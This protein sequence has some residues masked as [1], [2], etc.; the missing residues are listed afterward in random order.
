MPALGSKLFGPLGFLRITCHLVA[1]Y[2]CRVYKPP[3]AILAALQLALAAQLAYIVGGTAKHPGG[4]SCREH[5]V[6]VFGKYFFVL[7]HALKNDEEMSGK[8]I[9]Y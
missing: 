6:T 4:L 9:V 5:G 2:R 3:P 1:L 8:T 7:V